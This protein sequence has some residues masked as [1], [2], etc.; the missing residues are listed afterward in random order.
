MFCKHVSDAHIQNFFDLFKKE[1]PETVR[2][3]KPVH[4]HTFTMWPKSL[5]RQGNNPFVI[6]DS[7][8]RWCINRT[9]TMERDVARLVFQLEQTKPSPEHPDGQVHLQGAV[10]FTSK[11]MF[12]ELKRRSDAFGAKDTHWEPAICG[13]AE[14]LIYCTKAVKDGAP[15]RYNPTEVPLIYENADLVKQV[16]DL[17]LTYAPED[18]QVIHEGVGAGGTR[19]RPKLSEEEKKNRRIK[20]LKIK[21]KKYLFL[22]SAMTGCKNLCEVQNAIMSGMRM[23]EDP[24]RLDLY[25][26]AAAK[27]L[28]SG[29]NV[30]TITQHRH[31]DKI[32]TNYTNTKRPLD[33]RVFI[34]PPGCGKTENFYREFAGSHRIHVHDFSTDG[35]FFTDYDGED[36]LLF[37]EW[38]T[39]PAPDVTPAMILNLLSGDPV[40]LSRK[41]I[42][43]IPGQY[44]A[45]GLIGNLP[46]D[47]WFEHWS[48]P[49]DQPSFKKALKSRLPPVPT[50]PPTPGAKWIEWPAKSKDWRLER[51]IEFTI[52]TT[53]VE[54][55]VMP[56]GAIR[57]IPY[58]PV[59]FTDFDF[60]DDPPP[61]PIAP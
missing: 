39:K 58:K 35:K 5:E 61:P 37:D 32:K 59:V 30:D 38:A 21:K 45:I 43:N 49:F 27:V 7:D 53:R 42:G 22:D 6:S 3:T 56:Y 31:T 36:V 25:C 51:G 18:Q 29:R 54:R 24:E 20:E 14:Q 4:L 46:F 41:H 19:G 15:A 11:S 26:F 50:K 57:A 34:G 10:M 48:W 1:M 47:Q 23:E 44:Y 16:E 17:M 2:Y 60:G 9:R 55:A 8:G 33:V 40:G 12:A 28:Q 13:W 52:P